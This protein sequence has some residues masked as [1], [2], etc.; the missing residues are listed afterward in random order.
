MSRLGNR[1]FQSESGLYVCSGLGCKSPIGI[2]GSSVKRLVDGS[3]NGG[4]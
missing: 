1:S 4:E 2:G 3:V